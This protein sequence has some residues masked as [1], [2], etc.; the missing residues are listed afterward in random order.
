[1]DADKHEQT[2]RWGIIGCGDVTEVKSGP[3][4]Q[5]APHSSLAAVMRRDGAKARDY[6][7]RHG[8]ARWYDDAAA[9]IDDTEVD[10]VYVATPPSTH[11]LY[12]LMSIA[13]GKP[14]YVEKPMAMDHAECQAI[15]DAGRAAG[16]PVFVAYYRRA[17][18]RFA[19]VRELLFEQRVIGTPRIVNTVFHEPLDPR[20]QDPQHLH[21]HVLPEI[22]G[23]DIFMDMGCHTLDILDWL[24]GPITAVS[25]Q[26]SNQLG[27]YP[28]EDTVAMSFAFG[29]GMLGT[30]LWNFDSF[31]YHDR[32]EVIGDGGRIR[33][34]TFGDGPIHV[35][36]AE[37]ARDWL[38]DN[39][40]HIQQP[41]IESIVAELRGAVGACPSSAESG[42]RTSRVMDQVLQHYRSMGASSGE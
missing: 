24:F 14:V 22:S 26:A 29:N 10:A 1:M 9:L 34:A 40:L 27:A 28:A 38:V 37:G 39:P 4:L 20:Y 13:A 25:G 32:I 31:E 8:V 30:G 6:A 5:K 33:F 41:L 42:A 2:I 21:W 16:V 7:R 3:A 17:L 35:D 11:K 19:K 23:G 15:I 36:N 12:A 18:P